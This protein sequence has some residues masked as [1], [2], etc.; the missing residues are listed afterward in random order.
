MSVSKEKLQ[1]SQK[2]SVKPANSTSLSK[3]SFVKK[4]L[5]NT[6]NISWPREM[7]IV[8]TL[9][10]IFPNELFWNSLELKFKLNSLCW[11]LSD[12]GRKFLNKE[13]KKFEF[14]MP[15]AEVFSLNENKIVFNEKIDYDPQ[16]Q[17]K[18]K[19]NLKNYLNL[20]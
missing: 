10:T 11:L 7:K 5:K 18:K 20:W 14:K 8:K 17:L 6:E 3:K 15:V 2:K 16:I 1:T 19:K 4:F 12:D 13:Y 9:F